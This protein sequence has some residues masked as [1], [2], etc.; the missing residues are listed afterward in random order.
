MKNV[1][2]A[3]E[4]GGENEKTS[5]RKRKK[6]KGRR[7]GGGAG[8]VS[9]PSSF[10]SKH[11]A[12]EKG[13]EKKRRKSNTNTASQPASPAIEKRSLRILDV[14]VEEGR[15]RGGGGTG[16]DEDASKTLLLPSRLLP[17]HLLLLPLL[18][19]FLSRN[20]KNR[21]KGVSSP[22]SL[23]SFFWQARLLPSLLCGSG[24]PQS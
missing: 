15:E 13:K 20:K 4:E 17:L 3:K 1:A 5:R 19:L 12:R 6:K 10:L 24:S 11:S 8:T 7:T 14:W 2:L 21:L 22:S 23:F 18:L 16:D 9:F